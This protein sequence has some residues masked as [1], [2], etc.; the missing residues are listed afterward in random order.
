MHKI[1]IIMG[2]DSTTYASCARPHRPAPNSTSRTKSPSS[3]RTAP[4]SACWTYS[5]NRRRAAPRASSSP[6]PGRRRPPGMIAAVTPP[7]HPAC[8]CS[9][10]STAGTASSPSCK[11]RRALPV[12]TVA[13]DGCEARPARLVLGASDETP[14]Q[15]PRRLPGPEMRQSV[16]SD[17]TDAEKRIP[18]TTDP[19]C[20]PPPTPSRQYIRDAIGQHRPRRRIPGQ[21]GCRFPA[22]T[23]LRHA[24]F[25]ATVAIHYSK[26]LKTECSCPYDHEGICKRVAALASPARERNT[27]RHRP[28]ADKTRQTNFKTAKSAKHG[29]APY[30]LNPDRTINA[31][32][33]LLTWSGAAPTRYANGN[34]VSINKRSRTWSI[35]TRF[36]STGAFAAG[37][38]T[39]RRTDNTLSLQLRLPHPGTGDIATRYR[40]GT[41]YGAFGRLLRR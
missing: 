4:R 41:P 28:P 7:V 19:P 12:A 20:S 29:S 5:K 40:A 38:K 17:K 23:A 2:S 16:H 13:L 22:S 6:V 14:A 31:A 3:R 10:S 35:I 34:E 15:P 33:S 9:R 18:A 21:T 25:P 26:T 8:R 30:T 1:G 24:H 32:P 11:C 37:A 39:N 27:P 36:D